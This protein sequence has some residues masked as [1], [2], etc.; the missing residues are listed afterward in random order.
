MENKADLKKG[1]EVPLEKGKKLIGLKQ[2]A[3]KDY[4]AARLLFLNVQLHQAA[5]FANTCIEKELKACLYSLNVECTV[6][7]NTFKLLNLLQRY[8]KTTF[9]KL[10]SDF[11]KVLTKIYD[12]RYHEGLNPNYNFVIIKRKFLSELYTYQVLERKVHYRLGSMKN[13]DSQSLY[14]IAI[15]NKLPTVVLDNYLFNDITK[16]KFLNSQ[17]DVFEFRIIFNHEVIEASYSIPKNIDINKF[18]YEALVFED[19]SQK[20]KI[21]NHQPGISNLSLTRNGVLYSEKK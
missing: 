6:Q 21:S 17:D 15:Q 4:I 10:N 1:F 16:E 20:M 7:H 11:I 13:D 2:S 12:S 9:E 19:N 8:D 18:I 5:F 14:E 3:F